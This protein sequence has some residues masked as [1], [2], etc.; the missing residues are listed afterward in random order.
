[1]ILMQKSHRF[2]TA[3]QREKGDGIF[4]VV[5]FCQVTL[6][7]KQ[8][9]PFLKARPGGLGRLSKLLTRVCLI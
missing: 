4:S 8:F 9:E 6:D 2:M 3:I 5:N 7:A 1:M